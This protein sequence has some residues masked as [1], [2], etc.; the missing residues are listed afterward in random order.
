VTTAPSDRVQRGSANNPFTLASPERVFELVASGARARSNKNLLVYIHVPFCTSKCHFCDWVVGYATADLVDRGELQSRYVESLC[1]QIAAYAPVLRD[2]GY[3]VTNIYWGGGTPTRLSPQYMARIFDTLAEH[4]DLTGVVEHTAECSPE[5]VTRE[6]LDV[7]VAR[8]LNRVSTGAQ[9]FDP[10]ILRKMGRAHGPEQIRSAM[11]SFRDAGLQNFN[12][13][14]ITGFPDQSNETSLASVREAIDAEVPH[15]SFYMFRDFAEDLVAIKQAKTGTRSQSSKTERA[16]T[17]FAAKA[18][19]EAAGYE[20]YIV[21]YFAREPR[22]RFDS[23]DYYFSLRGDYFGFGAGAGGVLGRHALKSGVPSRYG[24]SNVR[25]FAA[26][27]LPLYAGAMDRMPDVLY[28][29]GYFK[30]FA[31]KTGIN[32]DRWYDQFGFSFHRFRDERP[33]IARWF[34]ER[35]LQGAEF[36][37]DSEGIKLTPDTWIETMMWRR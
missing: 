2:L 1:A 10:A 31:T 11:Q 19:F 12:I 34:A 17:Y 26:E 14:L 36:V 28:T 21:G 16:A 9:S 4:L 27:P 23:E 18:L 22:F 37:E 32:F 13:D 20:E 7:L 30:A 3:T 24:N 5:T 8:K 35:I 15:V 29:D 6:H 33:G 25:E